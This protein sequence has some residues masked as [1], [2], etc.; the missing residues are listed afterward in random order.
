MPEVFSKFNRVRVLLTL[1][2]IAISS[3]ALAADPIEIGATV[4][5]TSALSLTGQ[6][7]AN[8]MKLAEDDINNAGGINGR[9]LKFVFEDAM[10]SN[11]IGRAHV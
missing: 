9:K 5:L 2:G 6:Q 8:A 1:A 7:C 3:A 11:K 4:P 10:G